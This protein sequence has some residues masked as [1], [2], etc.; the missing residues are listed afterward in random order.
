MAEGVEMKLVLT[1]ADVLAVTIELRELLRGGI[2]DKVYS[3][4][5]KLLLRFRLRAEKIYFIVTPRRFGI[6]RYVSEESRRPIANLKNVLEGLKVVNVLNPRLDRISCIAFNDESKLIIEL[7]EPFN[8]IYVDGDDM[9][10]W[11]L[12]PQ[13]FRDRT[14]RVGLKY[15]MPPRQFLDVMSCSTDEYLASISFGEGFVRSAARALGVGS[16]LVLEAC[17][18]AGISHV[19]TAEDCVNVLHEVRRL[20][21]EALSCELSPRIYVNDENEL[22]SVT[23]IEFKIYE[24]YRCI[25]FTRFNDAVDE[26]FYEIELRETECK[27][28][29]EAE[30]EK[31]KLL[32]TLEEIDRKVKEYEESA[33][34]LR[35]KAEALLMNKY[36]ID[37][38]LDLARR[39]WSEYKD[40]FESVI[41]DVTYENVKIVG[42]NVKNKEVV[43]KVDEHI[44]SIP[45]SAKSVGQLINDLFNKAKEYESKIN[46]ALKAREEL[47]RRLRDVEASIAE[48]RLKLRE[49]ITVVEYG[50]REWFERFKWFITS[51]NVPVLAGKNAGQNE[52]LVKKYLRPWDL[53]FHADV[54]GASAVIARLRSSDTSLAERDL[55]EIATFAASN[56]RAWSIGVHSVDVYYVRGDQVSKQ[57]PSGEYLGRGSFMIYGRRNW[58]RGTPLSLAIGFRFDEVS[59]SRYVVRVLASPVSAISR[60]AHAYVVIQPGS[61][62]RHEVAKLIRREIESLVDHRFRRLVDK[63]RVESIVELVPGG[64][65]ITDKGVGDPIEWNDIRE[66][67]SG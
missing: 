13:S 67:F 34:K 32:K 16:E 54:P 27:R 60:L 39:C 65:I 56:S 50:V 45:I 21:N 58:L 7:I 12:R 61:T 11:C 29:K 17:R 38:L 23:P 19:S 5:D 35:S 3:T 46:R 52:V 53:F 9:I 33:A 57:P 2:V 14:I 26:Y 22:V 15:E 62:S 18:R 4:D 30:G 64:S 24:S 63:V 59:S 44:F 47:L 51:N 1:L 40:E 28:V 48:S 31:M 37:E 6:T 43:I 8:V 49:E 42:F 41:R 25:R 55:A 20:L 10:R 36:V 66:L